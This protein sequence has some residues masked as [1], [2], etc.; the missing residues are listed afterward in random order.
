MCIEPEIPVIRTG[1]L[2]H[3]IRQNTQRFQECWRDRAETPDQCS[4]CTGGGKVRPR[5]STAASE[6]RS[7]ARASPPLEDQ[8]AEA[9]VNGSSSSDEFTRDILHAFLCSSP[10][11]AYPGFT[12][13]GW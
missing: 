4:G 2:D 6:R 5:S 9:S 10:E 12:W 13:R 1:Q 8:A 7:A 3:D 11:K